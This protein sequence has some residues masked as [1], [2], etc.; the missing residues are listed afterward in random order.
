MGHRDHSRCGRAILVVAIATVVALVCAAAALAAR[1][2]VCANNLCLA[3]NGGIFPSKLPR[4]GSVPVTARLA[5]EVRTLDGSHPPAARTLSIDIDRTIQLDAVGLPVC[6]KGQIE[7]TNTAMARSACASAMVGSGEAEVEVA[8][9]EQNPFSSKGK[10]LLFNG[11]VHGNTTTVLLH[12]YVAIPAPTAIVVTAR[13]TRIHRG[14]FGL[15]ILAQIPKIAGGSGSVTNFHL[16]VGR[17]FSYKG[18]RESLLTAGC[19]TGNYVTEGEVL[20]S[21]G[22][23]VGVHHVFPCIPTG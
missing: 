1:E 13:V 8:F 11:G 21:G 12:A 7:T 19:P 17:R 15:H 9:P 5:G 3:D 10:V 2:V 14:R 22:T 18:R 4:H 16:T 20:F 6:R 23:E